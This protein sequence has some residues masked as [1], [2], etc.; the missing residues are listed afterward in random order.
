MRYAAI[1]PSIQLLAAM[2][3]KSSPTKQLETA[4]RLQMQFRYYF[5]ALVFTLLGASI[6]TAKFGTSSVQTISELAG[7]ALF[8]VSGLVALSYLEWE[9]L[10]REQLAHRDAYSDQLNQVKIAKLQGV[11]EFQVLSS[12]KTQSLDERITNLQESVG[13]LSNAAERRLS[14]ADIKYEI[15]RWSFV[16]ALVAILVSRGGAALAHVFGY[17]L[18]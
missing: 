1:W 17:E 13:K 18:L 9:P 15:W 12:G 4:E 3:D 7:W 10:I 8:A 6:Q 5:V 11:S 14:I 16:C 2:T